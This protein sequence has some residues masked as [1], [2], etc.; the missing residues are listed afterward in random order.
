MAEDGNACSTMDAEGD[1]DGD[2]VPND[3]DEFPANACA[4]VDSDGDGIPD[5]VALPTA[6]QPCDDDEAA[7][8]VAVLDDIPT[9]TTDL[10]GCTAGTF[11]MCAD[12]TPS[13]VTPEGNTDCTATTATG[14]GLDLTSSTVFAGAVGDADDSDPSDWVEVTLT[15]GTTYRIVVTPKT[16]GTMETIHILIAPDVP[17]DPADP[18]RG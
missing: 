3:A 13:V 2:T 7:E 1:C 6:D 15:K 4:S 5:S 14:C 16:D 9:F 11:A 17:A 10:P 8:L 12:N 18:G